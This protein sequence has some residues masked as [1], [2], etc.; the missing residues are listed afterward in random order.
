VRLDLELT[1]Q[2]IFEGGEGVPPNFTV[3]QECAGTRRLD[4]LSERECLGWSFNL[5]PARTTDSSLYVGSGVHLDGYFLVNVRRNSLHMGR[6][7]VTLKPLT[8]E[9][10]IELARG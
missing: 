1:V 9:R 7:F 3:W 4:E 8:A 10:A 5:V 2:D 6:T